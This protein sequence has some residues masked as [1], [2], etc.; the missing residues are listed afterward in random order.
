MKSSAV[1][2]GSAVVDAA[3]VEGRQLAGTAR[4]RADEVAGELAAEGRSLADETLSQLQTQAEVATQRLAE[5]AR[6]L[7]EQ[8]QALAE[9]RPEDA[10]VLTDYVSRAAD[11]CYAAADRLANL[12]GEI[13]TDGFGGVLDD[14]QQFARRRPGTFLLGA[15]VVGLGV[16]RYVKAQREQPEAPDRTADGTMAL[17]SRSGASGGAGRR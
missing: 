14:L 7:G 2:R 6:I 11:S 5:A 10:P 1:E 9:G 15:A 17:P 3:K 12:G 13:E 16:G 4:H 8:A